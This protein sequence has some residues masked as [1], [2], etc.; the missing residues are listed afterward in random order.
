MESVAHKAE[1]QRQQ[2]IA[3]RKRIASLQ[4][5]LIDDP[6]FD[7][8]PKRKLDAPTVL[9]PA[10]PSP[11]KKRK[12]DHPVASS[13]KV[14]LQASSK[15]TGMPQKPATERVYAK[16]AAFDMTS[17]SRLSQKSQDQSRPI[18]T[19]RSSAFKARPPQ[20]PPKVDDDDPFIDAPKR[21]DTL[22][23]IEDL[24][25]GPV[26]H[27]A[28]FDDPN[29]EHLEPNSG[30]RLSSR[31]LSHEDLQDHLRARYYLSPSR[32]YS[33]IRLLP[34][35]QGYDVPVEGDWVTIAVVAERG[36]VKYTKA[37]IGIG[38]DEGDAKHKSGKPGQP[39]KPMG[40][41]F[42]NI[43]LVD[44]GT[45]SRSSAT[46]GK[47]VL[48]GDALLTLLLFE[49]DGF[50]LVTKEAGAKPEKVYKGG[51]RGAFEFVSKI[52]E[53]DVIALLNP[54]VLKPLERSTTGPHPR[55]NILAVT[56]ESADSIEVIGRAK[57]LGLCEVRKKDDK[58]CRSWFDKRSGDVCE[59]HIQTAIQK[60][61][62]SRP[63]F[64]AGTSGMRTSAVH[65]HK[66]VYDPLR[67]I[68]L[69]PVE[70]QAGSTYVM[71]GHIIPNSHNDSV[72]ISEKIGREGQAKAQRKKA[73]RD[74]DIMLKALLER[75]PQG[76]QAVMKVKKLEES[77]SR[78]K[79][80]EK[81]KGKAKT[82]EEAPVVPAQ[83]RTER[84]LEALASIQSKQSH[85]LGPR[86]G[87]KIRSGVSA[88]PA[89]AKE[90]I[91]MV[92]LDD[93]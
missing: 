15:N 25:L 89:P 5:Q 19:Q 3:L 62:A 50:E 72:F 88:P 35:K 71:G 41:K 75:D 54:K 92:D 56:P 16:P 27:K 61:R 55:N 38:A 36:P 65:R 12:L 24:Q 29:F 79:V 58:P 91:Q 83:G 87:P 8:Q 66:P 49:S 48:R 69:K 14:A 59:Y 70:P 81:G 43:K 93:F 82:T 68:G 74:E 13:S 77:A 78:K 90:D 20:P 30:I 10:T 60:T 47:N 76:M 80:L 7:A 6:E 46:G 9:A 32:L 1:E 4:S 67:M 85:L 28:P 2:Q 17:L 33:A 52:K 21:D 44:F 18:E 53:G 11:K 40:K 86:P 57:D 39:Q 45:R 51:S 64:T 34:D 23:L 26:E 73:K 42:V 37:P 63:E 22:A 84:R 31:I